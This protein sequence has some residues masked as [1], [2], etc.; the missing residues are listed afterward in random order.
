MITWFTDGLYLTSIWDTNICVLCIVYWPP[1]GIICN[2][3]VSIPGPGSNVFTISLP[4]ALI[5]IVTVFVFVFVFV[6]YIFVIYAIDKCPQPVRCIHRASPASLIRLLCR[7]LYLS[8]WHISPQRMI[9][10]NLKYTKNKYT[11]TNTSAFFVAHNISPSDIFLHR[12]WST[13]K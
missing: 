10:T 3:Q 8:K 4:T 9:H 2:W 11:Y 7:P 6:I 1:Y 13:H 5:T 12:P